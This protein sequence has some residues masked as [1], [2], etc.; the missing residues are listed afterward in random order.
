[1]PVIFSV[2]SRRWKWIILIPLFAAAV[3]LLAT[4]L[5][6]K[7]YL[8]EVTAIPSNSAVGD[9]ARIFNQNIEG[10]YQELGSPDELDKIEGTA[11]LDTIYLAIAEEFNLVAHYQ[12][13]STEEDALYKTMRRLQKNTK[14]DRTGYGEL[15]IRVWDRDR[16][17]AAA[18]ANS[19]LQRLNHMHQQL[20]TENNRLVL[21]QLKEEFTRL[22][23]PNSAIELLD[24]TRDE[25]LPNTQLPGRRAAQL[26]QYAS[27]IEQYE[28]GL[29]LTPKALLV[30]EPA[31]PAIKADKPNLLQT[32]VLA[33]VAALLFSFLLALFA[34]G[35]QTRA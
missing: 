8:G 7:L 21:A 33:F 6:P 11:R 2:I 13:D 23:Q 28:V 1:M 30:V 20:R 14:I 16:N 27:L 19:F 26:A 22:Q 15:K 32:V 17:I 3:A 34:E 5:R 10:L 25:F 35:R 12:H 9:K 18:L 31:R 29:K 4:L 24:T